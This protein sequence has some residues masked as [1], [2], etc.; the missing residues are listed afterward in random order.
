MTELHIVGWADFQHYKDRWP[1]WIKNYTALLA[2]DDYLGLTGHRRA[3]LHGLWLAYAMSHGHVVA[4]TTMLSNR[5]GL[6]V[7]VKDLRE[8]ADAG[9]ITLREVADDPKLVLANHAENSA[10][11]PR[12]LDESPMVEEPEWLN[13]ADSWGPVASKPLAKRSNGASA[14]ATRANALA[15]GREETEGQEQEE[16]EQKPFSSSLS[17]S[18]V[19]PLD[20]D[21]ALGWKTE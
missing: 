5:L 16:Q 7:T 14:H 17:T 4:N 9:F 1:P 11:N 6:R 12:E 21:A 19:S 18:Y 3:I 15:R 13:D 2:N 20:F 8:L 10:T